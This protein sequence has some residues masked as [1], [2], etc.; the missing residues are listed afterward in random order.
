MSERRGRLGQF[1]TF[2]SCDKGRGTLKRQT[3]SQFSVGRTWS[4]QDAA[5]LDDLVGV[6]LELHPAPE[7]AGDARSRTTTTPS[8]SAA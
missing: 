1:I 3:W 2:A 6:A 8:R 4:F 7:S 5:T